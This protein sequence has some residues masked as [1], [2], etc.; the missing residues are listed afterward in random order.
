MAATEQTTDRYIINTFISERDRYYDLA[1]Q[2]YEQKAQALINSLRAQS[3]DKLQLD[4]SQIQSIDELFST[5]INKFNTLADVWNKLY[6]LKL[7]QSD[8]AEAIRKYNANTQ[9]IDKS[10]DAQLDTMLFLEALLDGHVDNGILDSLREA[11][12]PRTLDMQSIQTIYDKLGRQNYT[13]ASAAGGAR[14][15]LFGE[16]FEQLVLGHMQANLSSLFGF[17]EQMGEARSYNYSGRITPG[18]SDIMLGL[19]NLNIVSE[20]MALS[21][22]KTGMVTKLQSDAMPN[23]IEI[24][25][26]EAIDLETSDINQLIATYGVGERSKIIGATVKQWTKEGSGATLAHS[27]Y[28]AKLI[29][30]R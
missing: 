5:A 3:R 19:N 22:G 15:R 13:S 18:K 26:A 20:A 28:T 25:A 11:D 7:T 23:Y 1:A 16:M 4:L 27:N 24:D 2:Y 21:N 9:N 14:A 30:D 6:N 10:T 8:I 12:L 29:N 17:I